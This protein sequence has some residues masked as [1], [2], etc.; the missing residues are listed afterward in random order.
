M[1]IR[2]IF[3]KIKQVFSLVILSLSRDQV[4]SFSLK[5]HPFY[6]NGVYYTFNC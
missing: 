4:K 3:L 2:K 6:K 1:Q 5:S